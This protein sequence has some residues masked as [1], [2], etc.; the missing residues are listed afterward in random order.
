MN[1]ETLINKWESYLKVDREMLEEY[2]NG[3]LTDDYKLLMTVKYQA[4]ISEIEQFIK[5]LKQL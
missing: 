3:N 5:D 2:S 4:K 1:V